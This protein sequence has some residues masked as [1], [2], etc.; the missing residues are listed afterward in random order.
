MYRPSKFLIHV[1]D[2]GRSI[3]LQKFF[4]AAKKVAV[5]EVDTLGP[6]GIYSSH[7]A[8]IYLGIYDV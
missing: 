5:L 7:T 2:G 6:V 8:L 1:L 3:S 4:R